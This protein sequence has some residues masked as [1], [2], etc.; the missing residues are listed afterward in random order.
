MSK[1]KTRWRIVYGNI[2][3][4]IHW[5]NQRFISC[6]PRSDKHYDEVSLLNFFLD[7]DV[8]PIEISFDRDMNYSEL[9]DIF[10]SIKSKIGAPKNYLL[11][12]QEQ[13]EV[14]RLEQEIAKKEAE[15]EAAAE[16]KLA[17]EAFDEKERKI[18]EIVRKLLSM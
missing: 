17:K 2:S 1:A 5:S 9:V 16:R 6:F 10:E 7:R 3:K 18:E 4:L 11:S 13:E 14:T 15:E 12:E 8:I